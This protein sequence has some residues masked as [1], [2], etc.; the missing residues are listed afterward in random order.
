RQHRIRALPSP[1]PDAPCTLDQRVGAVVDDDAGAVDA[2]RTLVE[3]CG[4]TVAGGDTP[5]A[6][7]HNIGALERYPDLI[8]ADLRLAE[9]SGIDAVKRLRDEL[10][11]AIPAI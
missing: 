9:G 10:G 11:L 8:V 2:M 3:T 4:A 6:L 5:D 1:V 7:L